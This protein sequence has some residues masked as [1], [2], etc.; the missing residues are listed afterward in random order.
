[1]DGC[2]FIAL[3]IF[4]L[5]STHAM[6][7]FIATGSNLMRAQLIDLAGSVQ[8]ALQKLNRLE[9]KMGA[10]SSTLFQFQYS[11]SFQ[12]TKLNFNGFCGGCVEMCWG[13]GAVL[14]FFVSSSK[15][16]R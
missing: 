4:A 3:Y 15:V 16:R 10:C 13:V 8:T 11:V 7:L 6:M 14:T 2:R 9:T 5:C 1:M 12:L